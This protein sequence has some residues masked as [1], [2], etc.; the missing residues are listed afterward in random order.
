MPNPRKLLF[1][2]SVLYHAVTGLR[3]ELYDRGVFRSESYGLPVIGVGNLNMGGTGKSPMI[4]YLLRMFHKDYKLATLSR[5][6]KRKSKGFQL[7]DL[8]GLASQVGDE[9]LQFKN[10]FPGVT[11]AVDAN[12]REGV[13]ELLKFSPDVILL[14]DAFQHRKVKAGFYILLTAYGDLYKDD[15]LLPAG[16]LRESSAGAERADIIVITKCPEDLS[17]DEMQKIR[18]KLKPK[19]YQKLFF[20]TISYSDRIFSTQESRFLDEISGSDYCLVTG[21]A[22]PRPVIAYLEK[23]GINPQHFKFPDH[24]NFSDKEIQ[25]LQAQPKKILT[26]EKDFM[27]LKDRLHD[28]PLYYLP[29]EMKLLKQENDFKK[30][31]LNFINKK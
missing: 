17:S 9:P 26:T 11:V 16:N 13:A 7:V 14:D 8:N 21:I 24:H 1:P 28:K 20:A 12:R 29:I 4:E 22:N 10:K 30:S 3:N 25:K 15:L 27:R 2:F 31:I 19:A 6:Y 5:G 23:K 18:N